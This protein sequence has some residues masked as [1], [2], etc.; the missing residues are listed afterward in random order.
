[1]HFSHKAFGATLQFRVAL[2]LHQ[3][4]DQLHSMKKSNYIILKSPETEENTFISQFIQKK[5][6]QHFGVD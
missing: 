2:V 5:S 4:L 6:C 3:K 1:M